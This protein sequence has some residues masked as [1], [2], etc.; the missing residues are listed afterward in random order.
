MGK[1]GKST[2][3]PRL[4]FPEFRD[5]DAWDY[6][7][8]DKLFD[9]INNRDAAAGERVLAITQ[10]HGAIPRDQIDYHVS[11]T[12][13]SIESYKVV[14]QGDFIISLR[15]FQGGIEY[16]NYRGICSPAYIILRRKYEGSDQY[17]KPFPYTH[18][19]RT[20]LRVRSAN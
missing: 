8:G 17:F 5:V 11:V 1:N 3:M 13:K 20:V 2:A 7:L 6:T 9:P 4:R 18:F 10:E 19:T 12:E 16:S 15:S 14:E